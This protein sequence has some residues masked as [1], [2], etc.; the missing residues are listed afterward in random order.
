MSDP[1]SPATQLITQALAIANDAVIADI[2]SE[3]HAVMLPDSVHRWW[4][5][6]PMV[7]AREHIPEFVDMA[8]RAI[9]YALSAGL[10]ERH[11]THAHL[12]RITQA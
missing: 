2:E 7:D 8:Q 3:A 6:R 10:A 12:V 1:Q 11:P 5:V 4:D 9:D